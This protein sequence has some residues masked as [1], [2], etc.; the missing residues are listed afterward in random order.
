MCAGA[1]VVLG[2]QLAS[3]TLQSMYRA[4]F[5][6]YALFF[7]GH[8]RRAMMEFNSQRTAATARQQVMDQ[9]FQHNRR[10]APTGSASKLPSAS[11]TDGMPNPFHELK[12]HTD[13]RELLQGVY[14]G[15]TQPTASMKQWAIDYHTSLQRR[16]L[17]QAKRRADAMGLGLEQDW[18]EVLDERFEALKPAMHRAFVEARDRV[19]TE[20]LRKFPGNGSPL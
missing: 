16:T 17:Y 2:D 4:W 1:K 18:N 10:A 7:R 15:Q 20:A 13:F 19:M 12:Q 14:Y 6:D 5:R 8:T 11:P 9:H 3:T